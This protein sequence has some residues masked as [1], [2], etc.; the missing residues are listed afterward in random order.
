MTAQ[1]AK[2]DMR[3]IRLLAAA[4]ELADLLYKWNVIDE[5]DLVI[6]DGRNGGTPYHHVKEALV[7]ALKQLGTS[8]KRGVYE[9]L[10]SGM[11]PQEAQYNAIDYEH[12][13]DE[14]CPEDTERE[15]KSMGE[16]SKY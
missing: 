6:Q 1:S 3:K 7:A 4:K 9:G 12:R 16:I 11:D 8:N 10:T 15:K 13:Y 14:I 5:Y 2:L